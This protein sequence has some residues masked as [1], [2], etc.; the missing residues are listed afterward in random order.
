M[1][2]D[3]QLLGKEPLV[4]CYQPLPSYHGVALTQKRKNCRA[5]RITMIWREIDR[6][7]REA[8]GLDCNDH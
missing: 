5:S 1:Q 7:L 2:V 4:T 8:H 3:P 6:S